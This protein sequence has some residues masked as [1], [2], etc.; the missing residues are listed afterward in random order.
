MKNSDVIITTGQL[1]AAVQRLADLDPD[2]LILF[3]AAPD[4]LA[5][6]RADWSRLGSLDFAGIADE[7]AASGWQPPP[8]RSHPPA[9]PAA[10]TGE[11]PRP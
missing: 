6:M 11:E 3:P 4:P 2:A 5:V 1:A 7:A 9:A 8:W 10:D